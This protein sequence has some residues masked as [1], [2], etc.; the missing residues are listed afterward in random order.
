MARK[1]LVKLTLRGGYSSIALLSVMTCSLS[2]HGLHFLQFVSNVQDFLFVNPLLRFVQRGSQVF[3]DEMNNGVGNILNT[4]APHLQDHVKKMINGTNKTLQDNVTEITKFLQDSLKENVGETQQFLQ[5]S[6]TKNVDFVQTTATEKLPQ[7]RKLITDNIE[8]GTKDI[9]KDVTPKLMVLGAGCVTSIV[10]PVCI[11][12]LGT[13]L[14][15]RGIKHFID[16]QIAILLPGSVISRTERLRRWGSGYTHPAA[17]YSADVDKKLNDFIQNTNDIRAGI[18]KGEKGLTF[19]NLILSGPPG[20]GKTMWLD[21]FAAKTKMRI[22][23]VTAGSLAQPGAGIAA[24][25]KLI[26]MANKEPLIIAID[27]FDS[28]GRDRGSIQAGSDHEKLFNHFLTLAGTRSSK[29]I[30]VATTNR[31]H[32][33]DPAMIRRFQHHVEV[34]LPDDHA[35]LQ[36]MK[37]FC[38]ELI[39]SNKNRGNV[40]LENAKKVLTDSTLQEF[41]K[42][43]RELSGAEIRDVVSS[44]Y[45]RTL[46]KGVNALAKEHLTTALQECI[47]KKRSMLAKT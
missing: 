29:F 21:A 37:L 26:K 12:T 20:T 4:Q 25:D 28:L 38:Q 15:Y 36:Q 23:K 16:P 35:R 42:E 1:S 22:A 32:S 14:T 43:A 34:G 41:I 45:K 30:I 33:L 3:A 11:A 10:A 8:Q 31:A 13:W 9:V 47:A 17:I 7:F 39:L 19:D 6:L 18:Q 27:E 40:F 5:S 2:L 44:A 46:V 24:L